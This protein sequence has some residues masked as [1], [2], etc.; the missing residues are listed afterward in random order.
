M[1]KSPCS[2]PW[3]SAAARVRSKSAT[4]SGRRVITGRGIGGATGAA[5]AA[6]VGSTES[7]GSGVC[8]RAAPPNSTAAAISPA[9][10]KAAGNPPNPAL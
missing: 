8:T 4:W 7:S 5:G 9:E 3:L 2:K 10:A 1:A 6:G